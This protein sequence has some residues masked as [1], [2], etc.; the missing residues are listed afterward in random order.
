[1]K[2]KIDIYN[3]FQEIV[4]KNYFK[5]KNY[6]LHY[7][8]LENNNIVIATE[9][10]YC[11][12]PEEYLMLRTDKMKLLSESLLVHIQEFNLDGL[13]EY[14]DMEMYEKDCHGTKRIFKS[15]EKDIFLVD[16]NLLKPLKGIEFRLYAKANNQI[17]KIVT[18]LGEH[19]MGVMPIYNGKI[20]EK[21]YE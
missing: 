4:L 14:K 8:N 21:L 2:C 20:K 13:T 15:K 12:L 7:A 3:S 6:E 11:I 1:M 19:I 10:T 17:G 5:Y 16:N 18:S 9:F